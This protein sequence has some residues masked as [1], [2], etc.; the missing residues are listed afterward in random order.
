MVLPQWSLQT[1]GKRNIE[2]V[3]KSVLCKMKK[4]QQQADG[5]IN[6]CP[7][8]TSVLKGEV[9]NLIKDIM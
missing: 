2:F 4:K 9:E 7:E 6:A 5:I 1:G 8:G 3:I